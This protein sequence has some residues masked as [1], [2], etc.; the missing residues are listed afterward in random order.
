ML[1][2]TGLAPDSF[3]AGELVVFIEI[4]PE[5]TLYAVGR[6]VPLEGSRWKVHRLTVDGG[7]MHRMCGAAIVFEHLVGTDPQFKD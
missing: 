3:E 6:H 5:A 7:G 4:E 1:I 2:E